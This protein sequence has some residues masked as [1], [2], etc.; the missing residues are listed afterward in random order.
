MI[1]TQD[2]YRDG[3]IAMIRSRAAIVPLSEYDHAALIW[4]RRGIWYTIE[5]GASGVKVWKGP[6]WGRPFDVFRPN[7]TSA[8]AGKVAI[9]AALARVGESY[10][11]WNL[12][13]VIRKM[14]ARRVINAQAV[15]CTELVAQ[16]WAAAGVQLCPGNLHPTPTELAWGLVDIDCRDGFIH[17]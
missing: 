15:V 4:F 17:V 9:D 3:D 12:L 14:L 2:G 16:A 5:A 11:F 10:S 13:I 6:H 8:E 1:V 7:N